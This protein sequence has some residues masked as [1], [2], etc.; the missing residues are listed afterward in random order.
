M[1]ERLGTQ[2]SLTVHQYIERNLSDPYFFQNAYGLLG[3]N[4]DKVSGRDKREDSVLHS[5]L[6]VVTGH[7]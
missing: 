3:I 5:E 6:K 2:L 1:E 7:I 4:G